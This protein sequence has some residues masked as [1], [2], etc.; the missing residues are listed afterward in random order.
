MFEHI[1]RQLEELEQAQKVSIPIS[2]DE[3]GYYDKECPNSECLYQFKVKEDDWHSLFSDDAVFCPKCRHE[4]P[5]ESWW[6]TQQIEESKQ[7]ALKHIRGLIGEA[8]HA[9]A[10]DFNRRQPKGGFITMSM[11]TSGISHRHAIVPIPAQKEMQLEIQCEKCNANYAV[12]GSAFF[13][14]CCGHNSVERTFDDAIKKV[15]AKVNNLAVIRKAFQEAG[16]TDEG[17][18][19]CLSL[20]E[21]GILDCVVAFQRFSEETYRK[22]TKN[23]TIPFNA[24]QRLDT[25]SDLWKTAIQEGYE[26]WLT[27]QELAELTILF[28]K[29]HL[30]AHSEGIVDAKYI[31]KSTDNTYQV[32]QRIVIKEKDVLRLVYLIKT[33]VSTIRQKTALP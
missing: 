28:Q 22:F 31:A 32:G 17:E 29:R 23:A 3:N 13:C 7:Q 19:T 1:R 33:I 10:R 5:A 9:D 2:V 25:G 11:N 12:I 26:H 24:F 8:L 15:E 20:I 27:P 4:A 6:T 16:Q 21:T 18:I 14:P 30:L